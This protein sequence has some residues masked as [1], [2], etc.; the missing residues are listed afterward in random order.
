MEKLTVEA[1][2]RSGVGKNFARQTRLSGRIPGVVYG[3]EAGPLPLTVDP[4]VVGKVLQS[5]AG[6]NAVFTLSIKGHG[7][8]TAMI[9]DWQLDPVK[10]LLLHVD[11]LRI[12]LDTRLKVKVP[13]EVRGEPIGVKQQG[14]ILEIIQREIEVECLPGDIPDEFAVEVAELAINQSVRVS[15]LKVDSSK[16]RI[17]TDPARVI[18]HCVPPR[19]EEEVKPAEEAVLTAVAAPESA[20][21]ELIRKRKAE[22]E[23]EGEEAPV[24]GEKKK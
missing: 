4:R 1:E 3:T 6:H 9:R 13:V 12:A 2:P 10:G 18:V 7:K 24:E 22:A 23:E 16:V 14:G 19:Q 21:P 11:F 17:L 15:D 5:E 20:E 8:T